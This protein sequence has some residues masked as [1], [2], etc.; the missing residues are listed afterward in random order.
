MDHQRRINRRQLYLM[1]LTA[2]I[3][4]IASEIGANAVTWV[5]SHLFS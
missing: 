3:S 2:M 1:A 4:G 5:F